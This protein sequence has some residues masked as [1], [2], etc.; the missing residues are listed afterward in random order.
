MKK[1][2]QE[3]WDV[4]VTNKVTGE[5]VI[6]GIWYSTKKVAEDGA[7]SQTKEGIHTFK[8]IRHY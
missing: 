3:N 7:R 6:M 5:K 2:K 1:K 8:A 4:E